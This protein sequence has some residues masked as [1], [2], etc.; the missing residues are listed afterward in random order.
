MRTFK[1]YIII[2]HEHSDII[3]GSYTYGAYCNMIL[4]YDYCRPIYLGM[5]RCKH[6]VTRF[7]CNSEALQSSFD[8]RNVSA[9]RYDRSVVNLSCFHTRSASSRSIERP[10]RPVKFALYASRAVEHIMFTQAGVGNSIRPFT[11][12]SSLRNNTYLPVK[13]IAAA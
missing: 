11:I 6:C 12:T 13:P 1:D 2:W 7:P 8:C 10:S 4:C 5:R 3:I 9:W